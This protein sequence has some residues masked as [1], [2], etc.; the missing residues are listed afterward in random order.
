MLIIRKNSVQPMSYGVLSYIVKVV[1]EFGGAIYEKHPSVMLI[2]FKQR[3]FSPSDKLP[4]VLIALMLF[5]SLLKLIIFFE[6]QREF[7]SFFKIS[8]FAFSISNF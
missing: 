8:I 6:K 5:V 4:L 1:I 3:Q 2:S 7:F